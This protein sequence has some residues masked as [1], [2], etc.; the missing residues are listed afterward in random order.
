MPLEI[1][2]FDQEDLQNS[3]ANMSDSEIDDLA[4]GAIELDQNGKILKYNAAEGAITGRDPKEVIGKSFFTEI[5]PCTN[6]PEFFGRFEEGVKSGDLSVQFDYTFDYQMSPTKVKV[7]MK[8]ALTGDTY[9][10][11]VKRV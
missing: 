10:V 4:F 11:F 9:W 8:K 5:A 1:V 7:H 2:S 3:L 6:T